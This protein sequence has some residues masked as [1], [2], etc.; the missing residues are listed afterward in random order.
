MP[1]MKDNGEVIIVDQYSVIIKLFWNIPV[2]VIK[3]PIFFYVIESSFITYKAF[4][5]LFNALR[6][7]D[8]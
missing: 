2:D 7:S 3:T 6:P 8:V 5:K 4:A 1:R